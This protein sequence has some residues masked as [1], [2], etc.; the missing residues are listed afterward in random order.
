MPGPARWWVRPSAARP[1]PQPARA[2]CTGAAAG[3]RKGPGPTFSNGPSPRPTCAAPRSDFSTRSS[4]S[5]LECDAVQPGAVGDVV[6]N[7]H[8]ERV[9]LLEHHADP[10]AQPA[11]TSTSLAKISRPSVQHR[12][13]RRARPGTR[14]FMR[15]SVF[16]KVDFPQP[17][18][19]DESRDLLARGSAVSMPLSA[20]KVP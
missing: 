2:R 1:A 6:V 16:R 4:S 17:D 9:W 14:S 18:G 12:R 19:P 11:S 3:R 7:A 5:A 20:S 10:L 15:L 8:G 13:P